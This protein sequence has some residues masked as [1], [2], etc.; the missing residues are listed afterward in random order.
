MRRVDRLAIGLYLRVSRRGETQL[1]PLEASGY[2][3]IGCEKTLAGAAIS[4]RARLQSC[5]KR[6]KINSGL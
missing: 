2:D 1:G 5:R 3:F 6:N 4:V